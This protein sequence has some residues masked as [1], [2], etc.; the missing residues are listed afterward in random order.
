MTENQWK[1]SIIKRFKKN[2]PEGFAW[3]F[4]ARFKSG[5]PDLMLVSNANIIF[6]ELKKKDKLPTGSR[7]FWKL[8]DPIQIEIMRHMCAAGLTAEAVARGGNQVVVGN[9]QTG[10]VEFFTLTGFDS[11]I[12]SI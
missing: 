6:V 8:F 7:S 5:F 12:D 3:S 1:A 9:P 10:I 11:L 4:E 2:H